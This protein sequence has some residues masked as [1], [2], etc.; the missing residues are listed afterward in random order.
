MPA[1]P[2]TDWELRALRGWFAGQCLAM[3]RQKAREGR[4]EEAAQWAQDAEKYGP[5]PTR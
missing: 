4:P 3:A 2:L 1:K 5:P